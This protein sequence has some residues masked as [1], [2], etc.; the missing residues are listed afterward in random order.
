[1]DLDIPASSLTMKSQGRITREDHGG[2]H[3]R[4]RAHENKKTL[5]VGEAFEVEAIGRE[6][7]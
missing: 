1:M 3:G 6:V 5:R 7:L 2:C 4:H